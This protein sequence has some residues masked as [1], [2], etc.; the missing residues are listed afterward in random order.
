MA[1]INSLEN[2]IKY[3][4]ENCTC[5]HFIFRGVQDK[6][7][8]KLIPSVGR[9][10]FYSLE[11]EK[12]IFYQFKR[13]SHSN[14]PSN[15]TNNWEWLAIAQHY[16]LPTRLLDWTF[17]PLIALYFATQPKITENILADCCENGGAVYALHFCNYIN[18][19]KDKDP[20]EYEK[21]GVFQPPHV[22]SR[23]TGQAGIF[24]IQPNPG[25]ELIYE[26]DERLPDDVIKIEFTKEAAS[27]MQSQLFKIGVRHD[28]LFPDLDGMAKGVKIN[29]LLG[30]LHYRE[31]K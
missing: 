11:N 14:M 15:P 30:A 29:E 2:Y 7:F 25:Q 8:H 9:N 18:T 12:E 5:G 16:G 10:R 21:V 22:A 1:E 6:I 31:C 27:K 26:K 20:F 19:E 4:D 28:M 17:S 23:I 13:R 3:I 24:T